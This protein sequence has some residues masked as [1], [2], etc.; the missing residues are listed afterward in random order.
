MPRRS[1]SRASQ[2]RPSRAFPVMVRFVPN[3][4]G[5]PINNAPGIKTCWRPFFDSSNPDFFTIQRAINTCVDDALREADGPGAYIGYLTPQNLCMQLPFPDL[6]KQAG[7]MPLPNPWAAVGDT[8][9]WSNV[10]VAANESAGKVVEFF[11]GLADAL[12]SHNLPAPRWLHLDFEE[13]TFSTGGAGA[14]TDAGNPAGYW[15][16]CL[17]DP[18]ALTED[19]DGRGN[20]IATIN[21]RRVADGIFPFNNNQSAFTGNNLYFNFDFCLA[22]AARSWALQRAVYTHWKRFFPGSRVANYDDFN[23]SNRDYL[24]PWTARTAVGQ[25]WQWTWGDAHAPV[26][27]APYLAAPSIQ[28]P[29]ETHAELFLR[30]TRLKWEA[31]AR[32][33]QPE[34][35]KFPWV[36]E[37]G[38]EQFGLTITPQIMADHLNA[39]WDAG[40]FEYFGWSSDPLDPHADQ[41]LEAWNLHLAYVAA[42]L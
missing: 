13:S 11:A 7:D 3:Q 30:C 12:L 1:D 5:H 34:L 21:A 4:S 28:L 17:N 20:T 18:R 2:F 39:S 40:A 9:P 37:A 23:A 10:G 27:Y 14:E 36:I 33:T 41:V 38:M 16:P 24:F 6:R 8:T 25:A 19:V 42:H 32:G 15:T 29:G 35:A 26:L 31:I 22:L